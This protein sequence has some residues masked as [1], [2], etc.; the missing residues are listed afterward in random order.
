MIKKAGLFTAAIMAVGLLSAAPA[1]ARVVS[2]IPVLE[3]QSDQVIE[4][5]KGG[6]RGMGR[7]HN[8][9]KHYGWSRGR[10]HAYGRRFK[11]G[12]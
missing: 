7:G 1:S 2:Q 8:R 4:V 9:G 12:W 11:R 10:G 3:A 5:R 6:G